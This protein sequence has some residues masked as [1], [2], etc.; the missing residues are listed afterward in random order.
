MMLYIDATPR[1]QA[2]LALLLARM[3]SLAVIARSEPWK[4]VI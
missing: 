2:S 3:A 1:K 4:E